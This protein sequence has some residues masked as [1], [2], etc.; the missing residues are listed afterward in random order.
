MTDKNIQVKRGEQVKTSPSVSIIMPAYNVT[1][2]IAEALDSVFA[3]T[4]TDYEI[5]VINDGSPDTNE[6]ERVLKPYRERIV[7]AK[8]A[9]QGLSGARN[10]GLHIS[11][12]PFIALLDSDD[13]WMPNYLAVQMEVIQRDSTI[14][15][16]YSNAIIF[17]N[18]VDDGRE[19]MNL[20][21]SEGEV[22]F[23]RLV[24]QQCNVII[25]VT[26]R[27]EIMFRV[28]L[29][30]EDF[31]S[32]EDFDMWLRVVKKGGRIAYHRQALF[33]YRRRRDSL[34]SDPIW[35]CK[36]F[37]KVLEKAEKTLNLTANEHQSLLQGR[38]RIQAT[39]DMYEGKKAFFNGDTKSAIKN[40]TKANIFFKSLKI[41]LLIKFLPVAPRFFLRLYE[42]RDHFFYKISTKF[43]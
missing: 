43:D 9:N 13:V 15:V 11:C 31:R 3:Q 26:A 34:S 14:D 30:D 2:Y 10:T 7:Y 32:S 38:D 37:L 39:L 16:L 17:G 5:I 41:S 21:P 36:H 4:F 19:M 29:F 35:M 8:Q 33:R 22:T 25:S 12:A 23:E 1:M 20:L 40:F 27:R 24:L 18:T 28:G 6:L 42:A